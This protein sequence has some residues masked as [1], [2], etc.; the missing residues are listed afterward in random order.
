M[1]DGLGDEQAAGR[2][3][4]GLVADR[5]EPDRDGTPPSDADWVRIL[6]AATTVPDHGGLQPWRFAL[7]VGE[8]RHAFGDALV[9]GLQALRGDDLP[10]S[11]VAKMRG[12]AF[13]APCAVMVISSPDLES[14]VPEWEQVASASC[15]GYAMVLA[16][17]ALGYGA[18]W[19]S[20]PVLE[21]GP[22]R[23]LFALAEDEGLLGWVNFG[24]PGRPRRKKP[25]P[26][27]VDLDRLVSVI[28]GD[29]RI[30]GEPGDQ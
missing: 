30:L 21:S 11:V 16:A 9:A 20:A 14:N 18:V 23:S 1:V 24:S 22:V 2:W 6:G 7:I 5:P 17:T 28:G 26:L 3:V 27:S 15:T 13:A 12:K 10:D 8:G 25:L 19:K 4:D 29:R